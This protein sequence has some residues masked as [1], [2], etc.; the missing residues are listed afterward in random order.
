MSQAALRTVQVAWEPQV[1]V[2]SPLP[3]QRHTTA[4]KE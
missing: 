3:L 2:K 4:S 1:L